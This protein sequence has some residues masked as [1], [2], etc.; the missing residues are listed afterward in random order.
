MMCFLKLLF[1]YKGDD[2]LKYFP[3]KHYGAKMFTCMFFVGGVGV[4]I[5]VRIQYSEFSLLLWQNRMHPG[6][7]YP[8][9]LYHGLFCTLLSERNQIT[10]DSLNGRKAAPYTKLHPQRE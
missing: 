1:F 10:T 9:V 3:W 5:C 8:S 2:M 6:G 7:F 4:F